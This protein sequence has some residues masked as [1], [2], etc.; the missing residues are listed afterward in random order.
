MQ[1]RDIDK[2][3]NWSVYRLIYKRQC[4]CMLTKTPT[5]QLKLLSLVR[6]KE[7]QNLCVISVL[8][9]KPGKIVM[10]TSNITLLSQCPPFP[11]RFQL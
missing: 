10:F 6:D 4:N 5:C 7:K 2:N 3:L 9:T 1:S 8:W 11:K